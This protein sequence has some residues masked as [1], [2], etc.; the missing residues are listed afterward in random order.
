MQDIVLAALF[1]IHHELDR[2]PRVTGPAGIGRVAAVAAQIPGVSGVSHSSDPEPDLRRALA[3]HGPEVG[4]AGNELAH[5]IA[6]LFP[7][8]R[9]SVP[10]AEA[11]I[12]AAAR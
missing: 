7:Y 6:S 12:A 4:D 10:Q 8:L 1:E 5:P 11:Q 3:E 2:D 9:N